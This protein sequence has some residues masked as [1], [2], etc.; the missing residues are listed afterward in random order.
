[1]SELRAMR[2]ALNR[3]KRSIGVI[4][5]H[6]QVPVQTLFIDTDS[7]LLRK[8]WR[9]GMRPS[10]PISYRLRLG[11]RFDPSPDVDAFVAELERYFHT[12]LQRGSGCQ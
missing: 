1:M 5:K 2:A 10:L 11:R 3:L 6:A 9:F 12:E 8:G 7:P 4:A